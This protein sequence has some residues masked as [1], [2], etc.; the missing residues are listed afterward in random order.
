MN[1]QTPTWEKISAKH[2]PDKCCTVQFENRQ[3]I[4]KETPKIYTDNK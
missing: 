4:W 3:E 2:I 1:R